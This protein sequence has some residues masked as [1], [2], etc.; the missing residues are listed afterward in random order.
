MF[1]GAL[2]DGSDNGTDDD[3]WC[4]MMAYENRGGDGG[5][6]GVMAVIVG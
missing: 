3:R 6:R 4:D 1:M 5:D 2:V